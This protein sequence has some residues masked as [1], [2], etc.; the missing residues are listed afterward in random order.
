MLACRPVPALATTTGK[1][2]KRRE[3]GTRALLP[4]SD[5]EAAQQRSSAEDLYSTQRSSFGSCA[6]DLYSTIIGTSS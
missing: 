2:E 5:A 3:S 4:V 1:S 6:D